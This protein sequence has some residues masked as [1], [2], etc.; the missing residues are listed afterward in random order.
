MKLLSKI[1]LFSIFLNLFSIIKSQENKM[2]LSLKKDLDEIMFLDQTWR[3]LF[4]N[5]LPQEKRLS[6]LNKLNVTEQIFKEKGWG[7]VIQ[8]DSINIRKVEKI[9]EKYDYPVKSLVGEPTNKSAWYVIQHSDKIKK[10]LPIIK[11]AAENKEIEFT[12][13]A[14]MYDRFLMQK[15]KKQ[16]YGT[17]GYGSHGMRNG[18]EFSFNIIW[19]IKNPEKVNELRKS[20]GFTQTIEEYA[21]DLYGDDFQYK[22]YTLDEVKK[23]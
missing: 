19:P 18:K 16:K 3:E 13:Y 9:I 11:K 23:L 20:V 17:Q 7:L 15:G 4:D 6:L 5:N 8:Q 1:L 12:L 21:K 22:I 14:M 2:N 10:Y